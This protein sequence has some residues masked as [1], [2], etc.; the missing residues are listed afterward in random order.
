MA[1][2]KAILKGATVSDKIKFKQSSC[3]MTISVGQQS[4]EDERFSATI[5]LINTSFKSCVISIDDSLQRHTMALNHKKN[6]DAFYNISLK[7]G[8]L[9]LERNKK[10]LNKLSIPTK[11]IR[12]DHWLQHKDFLIQQNKIRTL[13][14]EDD[15]YRK[16]FTSSVETFLSKYI[17]RTANDRNFDLNRARKLSFDF[18]LEECSALTIWPELKCNF[19]VYPNGHNP[20]IEATKKRLV[21]PSFP[22]LL[23]SVTIIFRNVTQLEPQKF[24]L[25]DTME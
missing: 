15:E 17:H 21:Y 7:E 23:N 16:T 24:Y 13:L 10:Y 4:H 9:W 18:V 6:A 14:K 8:D 22:D 11:L 25:L 5:D 2:A 3:L 12:W 19:E 20:A 1:K